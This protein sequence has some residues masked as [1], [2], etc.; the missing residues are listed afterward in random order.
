MGGLRRRK[1]LELRAEVARSAGRSGSRHAHAHGNCEAS[2]GY[3]NLPT[4]DDPSF[5]ADALVRPTRRRSI[6]GGWVGPA[7]PE[8]I[9]HARLINIPR[10]PSFR[11]IGD[12]GLI[13]W[14]VL[15]E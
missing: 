3:G 9:E 5:Q 14:A 8:P 13:I 7:A 10:S 1:A 4:Q 15:I 6:D 11:Q 12:G 2:D